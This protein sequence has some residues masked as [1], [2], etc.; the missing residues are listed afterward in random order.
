MPVSPTLHRLLS[1]RTIEEEHLRRSLD[2]AL[3]DLHALERALAASHERKRAGETLL[4]RSLGSTEIADRAAAQV[5]VEAALGRSAA[6]RPR[7]AAA[8]IAATRARHDYLA[9]RLERRQA[10]TLVEEAQAQQA[11]E[12][13]RRSQQTLD[14]THLFGR[15]KGK[16]GQGK[17]RPRQAASRPDLSELEPEADANAAALPH[18]GSESNL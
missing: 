12:S 3:S 2:S 6:L 17:S 5:E 4:A 16:R 11:L 10:E 1:V 9:K 8:Q 15:E 14:E 7:I 13:D 18:S